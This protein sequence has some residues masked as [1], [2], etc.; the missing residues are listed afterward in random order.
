[1]QL[2][3][4]DGGVYRIPAAQY[5]TEHFSHQIIQLSSASECMHV[6]MRRSGQDCIIQ[7][8]FT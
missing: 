4:S 7:P 5:E 6:E 3:A 1:V 2:S 8:T